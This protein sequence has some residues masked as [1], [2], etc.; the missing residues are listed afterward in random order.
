[1]KIPYNNFVRWF[2]NYPTLDSKLEVR[3]DLT[4][5]E[6]ATSITLSFADRSQKCY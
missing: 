2:L 5:S 3:D 1:M 6:A 4:H